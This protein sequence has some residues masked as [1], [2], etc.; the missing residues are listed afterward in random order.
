MFAWRPGKAIFAE[1][2][3][4]AQV[5]AINF[6]AFIP[7]LT[8]ICQVIQSHTQSLANEAE[9]VR[10]SLSRSVDE[11]GCGP[12]PP[13]NEYFIANWTSRIAFAVV[14]IPNVADVGVAF[15]AFQ[16]G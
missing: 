8:D 10:R 9:L 3:V 6:G 7:L 16:F 5:K 12:G 15:G 11:V 1:S 14:M 2:V 4:K 13:Q